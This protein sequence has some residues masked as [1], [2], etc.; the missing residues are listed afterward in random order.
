MN[1]FFN[2][3]LFLKKIKNI[4]YYTEYKLMKFFFKIF[5]NSSVQ[6]ASNVC[7]FLGL[8]ITKFICKINGRHN[9]AMKNL[10]LCFPEKTDVQ[11]EQIM[12]K[13]YEG[14]GRFVGEYITQNKID[15]KWI[16]E[17]VEVI[18]PEIFEEYAK[19]GFFGITAHFSNWEI[20]HKYLDYKGH[21]L[22]IIYRKQNNAFIEKKFI[23]NRPVNQIPKGSNSMRDIMKFIKQKKIIGILIDQRDNAAGRLPFFGRGARTGVA[24]QR[25]SLKYDYKMICT[26]VCRKQDD[27]TKFTLTFYPPLEIEKTENLDENIE[28]LTKKTLLILEDWITENPEEWFWIYD[29]WK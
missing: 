11:K 29:R 19:T 7:G 21:K 28:R 17:N 18:N 26:K 12:D 22:N 8:Y 13:F 27:P 24:I 4:K 6:K 25:L 16:E 3:N 15:D 23:D 2:K 20:I 14:V 5:K 10:D 9:L 1:C